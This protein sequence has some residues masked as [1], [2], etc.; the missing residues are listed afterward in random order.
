[1]QKRKQA[2]FTK[3]LLAF[4]LVLILT[5]CSYFLSAQNNQDFFTIRVIDKNTGRGVPLVE[6]RTT[7]QRLYITDS[8]GVIAFD[9]PLLMNQQVSFTVFSHGYESPGDGLVFNTMAGTTATVSLKRINIAERLYRITGQDIYGESA[10]VGITFPI[11][12]Q[13]LNG[14]VTGQDTFIETLY[15]G[16]LYWFWGDTFGPATFNGKASGAT[17]ELPGKGGLNPDAGID[18]TYFTDSAGLNKPMCNI[19]GPGLVWIDWLLT[20]RDE[21]GKE[22]LYAKYS[23]TKTL[24]IDYERGIAVFNDSAKV[25]ESLVSI[26]QWLDKVHSSGHPLRVRSGGLEYLYIFDRY[27]L[28]R[29]RADISYIT[30]PDSYEHFTC[31]TPGRDEGRFNPIDVTTGSHVSLNPSSVFWNNFRKHWVM[32]AYEFTGGVW[33]LEGDTPTGPWVYGKKIVEHDRYDFYNVGQHPLF[34][35]E[36]GRLIYFEGTYTTGFSGNKNPTP[37]YDYNQMMYRL[38]LDDRRLS[39]PAPVY[40]LEKENKREQFLMRNEIDS[41]NLWGKIVSIPFFAFPVSYGSDK[42][43]PVYACETKQGT[44][45]TVLPPQNKAVKPL[46]Y[47]LP[48]SSAW[49]SAKDPV[50]GTWKCKS[51]R[52][53]GTEEDFELLLEKDG[54]NVTGDNV[55]EGSFKNDS[56][57]ITI[58]FF[59]IYLLKARMKDGKLTGDFRKDDGTQARSWHGEKVELKNDKLDNPSVVFLYEYKRTGSK[60]VFYS[61]DPG[62]SDSSVKRTEQAVCRVWRNPSSVIELDYKAKPVQLQG[63]K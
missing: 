5:D 52:S 10:K 25:F 37:L 42:V 8:N 55:K 7:S 30:K 16:K 62:L 47:A 28:E 43:I 12:N 27:G 41:L 18:L 51:L 17:S 23:R 14:K 60:E 39:L 63:A 44:Q 34:D 1:M 46:F 9:D 6:F 54:E 53:G 38:A 24:D 2:L 31:L 57:F 56:L 29:V 11:R 50:T 33:F 40:L 3:W 21:Y 36:N 15:N 61:V 22:R 26:D 48:V 58:D 4:S 59:G 19:P 32:I 45:L 20:L 35:Q 13:G 49:R